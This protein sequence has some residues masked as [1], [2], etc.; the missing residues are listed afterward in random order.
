MA[1]IRFR[2]EEII[3][4][5]VA[6]FLH[7]ALLGVLLLQPDKGG[8]EFAGE[9][10]TVSLAEDVSLESA[11]PEINEESR[12]AVA[13]ELSEMV[14]PPEATDPEKS[15]VPV[16]RPVAKPTSKP[17]AKPNSNTS[18]TPKAKP[19]PSQGGA[20]KFGKA[21]ENG[22]GSAANS[23]ETDA[24]A[25]TF[26][27]REQAS[28]VQAINRKIKPKW[29]APQGLDAERL[30]TVVSFRLNRDGSLN[31]RPRVVR[32]SGETASN[33][34]QKSIHA[35]RAVRAVLNAA[36]FDNL[37]PEFYDKWKYISG[38]RF[39]RNTSR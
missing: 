5:G 37:P 11:A 36:P 10:V 25:A 23:Q 30:V 1:T 29:N 3:G 28:L 17:P 9:R 34:A 38:V 20:S 2:D 33:R 14:V 19:T 31:G 4:L 16:D 6:A 32:Q 8:A 12:E 22:A 7:V 24:T 21:F 35:E 18:S 39:D 27:P 26:G 15:P 13:P